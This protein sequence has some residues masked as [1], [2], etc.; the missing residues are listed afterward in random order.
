MSLSDA[1]VII[2][3]YPPLA[4]CS[5]P[6]ALLR[7]A[8]LNLMVTRANRTWKDTDQLLYDRVCELSGATPLYLYLNEAAREDVES[9]TGLL[10]PYTR[11]RKLA[12][13]IYQFGFTAT[14]D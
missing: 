8:A 12:Y 13:K 11:M 5:V 9:F 10:P 7:E 2:V 1:D 3:E 4:K 14:E 6:A